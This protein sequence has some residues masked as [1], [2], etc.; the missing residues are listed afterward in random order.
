VR[1]HRIEAYETDHVARTAWDRVTDLIVVSDDMARCVREV[2]PTIDSRTQFHVVHNGLDSAAFPVRTAFDPFR[3]GWCGAFIARKNPT[4]ALQ[5]LLEL[6][7]H[8]PRY[9]LHLAISSAERLTM[10]A[11]CHQ[12]ALLRLADALQ[13]EGRIEAAS[14]PAWHAANGVLLSTSLHES[15]GYAIAEAAASG[16]ALAVLDH[17]GAAEFWP[18]ETRF[19]AIAD[20]V[21]LVRDAAPNRWRGLASER[22]SLAR[23]VAAV[24]TLLQP[25]SI[26]ADGWRGSADYWER[27]YRRGGDSGAGSAGRLARFKAAFLNRLVGENRLATV[28]ELGCGD[29]RQLALAAY[30]SY[31]GVDVSPAAIGLCRDRFAGDPTKRF[32]VDGEDEVPDVDVAMSLDVIFHLVEDSAFD[33]HMRCLFGHARRRVVLYTSDHDATTRDAHVRHRDVSAWVRRNAAHW[34]RIAHVRNP[35]PCD[36]SRPQDTSFADFHVYARRTHGA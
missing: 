25:Q 1:V 5:I 33:A 4:L 28:L 35:Y 3:I 12:A 34:E 22:F 14:M 11:F 10:E 24:M 32:V 20:A 7:R 16:C 8:D 9:R 21:R 23:Q 29:G 31:V 18:E 27:R 15:F 26:G 17:L 30:E 19:V 36:P 13:F 6:R 2:C